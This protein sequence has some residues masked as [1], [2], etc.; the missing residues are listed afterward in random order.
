MMTQNY[1]G[2]AVIKRSN[3]Q[4]VEFLSGMIIWEFEIVC[5]EKND[6]CIS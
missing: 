4:T 5:I 3:E 6:H 2:N 1:R